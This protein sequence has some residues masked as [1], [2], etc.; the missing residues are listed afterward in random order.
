[1]GRK[2]LPVIGKVEA[3]PGD[4]QKPVND[5]LGI[6]SSMEVTLWPLETGIRMMSSVRHVGK[7]GH[8]MCPRTIIRY[9]NPS[10]D[11]DKIDGKFFASVK[12]GI[13]V[14]A[15]SLIMC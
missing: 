4:N 14:E 13:E 10:R 9:G 1:M 15:V 5:L 12:D 7:K 6:E 8:F 11:V 3:N 2:N